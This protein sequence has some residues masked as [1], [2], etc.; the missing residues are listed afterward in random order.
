V[1]RL[2]TFLLFLNIGLALVIPISL[3][4]TD[5]ALRVAEP[6]VCTER[7]TLV[8]TGTRN[9]RFSCNGDDETPRDVSWLPMVLVVP[10]FATVGIAM[11]LGLVQNRNKTRQQRQPLWSDVRTFGDSRVM[12]FDQSGDGSAGDPMVVRVMTGEGTKVIEINP[13]DPNNP[14]TVR[15]SKIGEGDPAG[16]E[17]NMGDFF[18]SDM[19]EIF[20]NLPNMANNSSLR[21]RL[22]QLQEAHKAGLLTDEEFERKKQD[23]LN[24]F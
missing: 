16:V 3:M 5:V 20:K 22:E 14:V 4:A 1:V 15:K 7:E 18:N 11:L 8:R 24:S 9:I 23:I 10:L 19:A 17:I 12:T 21:A 6:F 13:D 2:L